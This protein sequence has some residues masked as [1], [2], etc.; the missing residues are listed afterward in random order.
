MST[1][2]RLTRRTVN[3]EERTANTG[4]KTALTGSKGGQVHLQNVPCLDFF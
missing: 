4:M 1:D 3:G 2:E